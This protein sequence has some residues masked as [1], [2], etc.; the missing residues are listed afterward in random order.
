MPVIHVLEMGRFKLDGGAMF[1]VVPKRMWSKLNPPDNDNLCTWQMR[2]LLIDEG[3]RKIL[4][5]TGIGNKQDE[6]FRSH[7]YP[8][9]EINL[10]HALQ[11]IGL[12]REDITDVLL[13][14]FHFDHVGGALTKTHN[15]EI[16]PSFPNAKYWT[17]E[18]HYNWAYH[19]NAREAAS[20][21]KENFVPL[22]DL[23]L[24]HFIDVQEGISFSDSIKLRFVYGHTEAMMLPQIKLNSGID[25][26]YC[27]DLIPSHCHIPLP[28]V[29][30]YDMQPLK[31][32]E[33]KTN[34]YTEVLEKNSILFFEH[35]NDM[36]AATIKQNESGKIVFDKEININTLN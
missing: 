19:P 31:S 21:L 8:S 15:G 11:N 10:D 1:G 35:D 34:L 4:V 33:E 36:A 25:M 9:D 29:M 22:K 2:C 5:D 6:K 3:N 7:F 26:I 18:I 32:L 16:I 28:Y 23:G 17:N 24:L 13:T 20:F 27:A 30:S 12:T 14:H